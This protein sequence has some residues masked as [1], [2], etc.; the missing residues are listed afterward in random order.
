MPTC[1]ILQIGDIHYPVYK[2]E[3]DVDNKLDTGSMV[4]N[5]VGVNR[6]ASAIKYIGNLSK[7]VHIDF[8]AFVGD[9]TDAGNQEEFVNSLEYFSTAFKSL[10]I[11][12]YGVPGNHDLEWPQILNKEHNKFAAF[13]A[14][15]GKY[16][17]SIE[18]SF[19]N[20]KA[21]ECAAGAGAVALYAFNSC[22]GCSDIWKMSRM[23]EVD[24]ESHLN[25][26]NGP[27]LFSRF[28]APYIDQDSI[29]SVCHDIRS[30]PHVTPIILAHHNIF[31]QRTP[32]IAIF[33]EMLNAGYVR[34]E[35]KQLGRPIVYLHGHIHDSLVESLLADDSDDGQI[36]I[37][38][39]SAPLLRDG[40]NHVQLFT[41]DDNVP[42]GVQIDEYR[43]ETVGITGP[44]R[45][46]IRFY[47][48]EK[49]DRLIDETG[50]DIISLVRSQ[51]S[52]RF[53]ELSDKFSAHKILELEF[54]GH[55]MIDR[56][57]EFNDKTW[58]V[59]CR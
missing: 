33:P 4:L 53:S 50:K 10:G 7:S 31:P 49:R 35:L 8:A 11:P 47:G 32:R 56:T 36:S 38:A 9:F 48:P 51:S 13:Q 52:S 40:F 21:Y 55:L 39:I 22:L 24:L 2:N 3:A 58:R 20:H 54:A 14:I 41:S 29:S 59:S 42:L 37:V 26:L 57:L 15:A 45:R 16:S 17:G 19:D 1:S 18:L 43:F 12:A 46:K 44:K 27:D 25:S 30:N 23:Y 6:I 5:G 34:N 28:D